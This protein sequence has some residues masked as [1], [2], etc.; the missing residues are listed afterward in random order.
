MV[1]K[2]AKQ[3]T[4]RYVCSLFNVGFLLGIF[5]D[6]EDRGDVPLERWLNFIGPDGVILQRTEIS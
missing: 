4:E 1:E 5:F 6:P 2:Y 3:E